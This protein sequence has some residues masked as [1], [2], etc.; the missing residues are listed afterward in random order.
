[1]KILVKEQNI[2]PW[3]YKITIYLEENYCNSFVYLVQGAQ[4]WLSHTGWAENL[5]VT[6]FHS[7]SYLSSSEWML[8][9]YRLSGELQ[10]SSLCRKHKESGSNINE[11]MQQWKQQSRG[12]YQQEWRQQAK[13]ILSFFCLLSRLLLGMLP[14]F[15]MGLP[16]SNNLIEKIFH[17]HR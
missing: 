5:I 2:S 1:M 3:T 8:K 14:T 12:S 15:M 9:A 4:K 6:N 13:V 11:G 16:T 17:K 7:G 10:G